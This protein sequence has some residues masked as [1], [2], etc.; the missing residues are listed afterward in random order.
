MRSVSPRRGSTG[1]I[2]FIAKRDTS[3]RRSGGK[4]KISASTIST[5]TQVSN[6]SG[7]ATPSMRQPS[8]QTAAAPV[9]AKKP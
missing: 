2:A 3:R 9:Q 5:I 4:P 7:E 1:A 8:S 6:S